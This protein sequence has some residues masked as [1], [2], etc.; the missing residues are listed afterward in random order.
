M[1]TCASHVHT[2]QKPTQ[3]KIRALALHLLGFND[4]LKLNKA[5]SE[6]AT[7]VRADLESRFNKDQLQAMAERLKAAPEG[8]CATRFSSQNRGLA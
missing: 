2:H 5:G 7:K 8:A 1:R 3:P 6:M 4:D